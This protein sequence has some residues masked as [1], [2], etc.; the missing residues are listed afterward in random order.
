MVC[1]VNKETGAKEEIK[2]EKVNEGLRENH[3]IRISSTI[4]RLKEKLVMLEIEVIKATVAKKEKKE[5]LEGM[6]KEER[7][8]RKVRLECRAKEEFKDQQDY[9]ER[10]ENPGQLVARAIQDTLDLR[11]LLE[12]I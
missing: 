7:K 6:V 1:R 8:E 11:E 4:P 2:D 10:L 5:N 12:G 3:T 9:Q